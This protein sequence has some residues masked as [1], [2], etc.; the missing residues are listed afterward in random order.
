MDAIAT[1]A[2]LRRFLFTLFALGSVATALELVLM[3]HYEGPWQWLPIA[4]LVAG[5]ALAA[6]LA[7]GGGAARR[8]FRVLMVAFA[9]AGAI[10][11]VLHYR[12]SAEFELEKDA[13]LSGLALFLEA[14]QGVAPPALAPGAL[15]ALGLIGWRWSD[16]VAASPPLAPSTPSPETRS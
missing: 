15:A 9:A 10:G 4:L 5:L 11:L 3:H 2:G 7:L 13:G 16:L 8:P 14:I 1:L 12:A 6:G